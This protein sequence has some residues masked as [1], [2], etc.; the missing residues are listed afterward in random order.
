MGS[1]G[2][3]G[4]GTEA[5][6]KR[7]DDDPDE[8][9][10]VAVV[11]RG[12][13]AGGDGVG[14]KGDQDQS[15]EV[16]SAVG[17]A[18]AADEKYRASGEAEQDRRPLYREEGIG[19]QREGAGDLAAA[20]VAGELGRWIPA[21]D[22]GAD[23]VGEVVRD[24][25]VTEIGADEFVGGVAVG[26]AEDLEGLGSDGAGDNLAGLGGEVGQGERVGP[27]RAGGIPEELV[28]V[29]GEFVA[30]GA[31]GEGRVGAD[32]VEVVAGGAVG[33]ET[34]EGEDGAV[35]RDREAAVADEVGGEKDD[36]CGGKGL[37]SGARESGTRRQIARAARMAAARTRW[38]RC[39]AMAKAVI[40]VRGRICRRGRWPRVVSQAEGG[41]GG[42]TIRQEGRGEPG[43]TREGHKARPR[44]RAR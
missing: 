8:A 20:V 12:E 28:A 13:R 32:A 27:E 19:E 7:Q 10:F 6:Q 44:Q 34:G 22:A 3:V 24:Q 17:A 16:G 43:G 41:D 9:G 11:H 23:G 38:E 26:D 4:R 18:E 40:T 5:E 39:D 2:A 14:G 33:D 42:E 21:G 30:P 35:W 36:E 1:F 15:G 31:E 25:R 29:V 37:R